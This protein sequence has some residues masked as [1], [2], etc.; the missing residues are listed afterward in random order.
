MD[1]GKIEL[2]AFQFVEMSLKNLH[3]GYTHPPL[4]TLVV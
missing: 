4:G 1:V 2:E 3:I